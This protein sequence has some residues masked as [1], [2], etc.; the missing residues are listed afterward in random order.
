MSGYTR[1]G[2]LLWDW[3]PFTK[4]DYETRNLWLALYTSASARRLIPGLWSGGIH[5]MAESAC[6]QPDDVLRALD[7]LLERN[8]V[9]YDDR[10][11]I[12]RL[13]MLPDA[14][15]W[16]ASPNILKG[17]WNRFIGLPSC[18]VRD[19]HVATLRWMIDHGS[20]FKGG[21]NKTASV[22]LEEAWQETFGT[23]AVPATRRRG[24]RQMA[25]SDTSTPVQPSLFQIS[26]GPS[27]DQTA[28]SVGASIVPNEGSYSTRSKPLSSD[29][30]CVPDYQ[31]DDVGDVTVGKKDS[32]DSNKNW[33]LRR[34]I[35]DL[36]K[37]SGVGVG[38]GGSSFS[39]SSFGGAG[40]GLKPSGDLE[41][42][43]PGAP[44]PY[45]ATSAGVSETPNPD[46][47]APVPA[48]STAPAHVPPRLTL[49]PPAPEPPFTDAEVFRALTGGDRSRAREGLQLAISATIAGLAENGQGLAE[50]ALAGRFLAKKPRWLEGIGGDPGT[51]VS[52]W[53]AVPGALQ[54]AIAEAQKHER[55]SAE[56]AAMVADARRTLGH[57]SA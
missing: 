25:E 43:V 9:E 55:D 37:T 39:F 13:T 34:G 11:R 47:G 38:V 22:G 33:T 17:W 26:A 27:S 49:V 15:D 5:V 12:L 46:P 57:V 40:S 32:N 16:P 7:K 44:Y 3:E 54:A 42:E 36:S 1:L 4:L 20:R 28:I 51:R 56:M 10:S 52:V 6:M 31:I 30:M 24:R 18:Q 35:E 8:M 41:R 19:A 53:V 29:S 21:P 23:I 2:A 50:I 45:Q 14:G 48:T